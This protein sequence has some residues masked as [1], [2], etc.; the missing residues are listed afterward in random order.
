[1]QFMNCGN[2]IHYLFLKY[3]SYCIVLYVL[4]LLSEVYM[5]AQP[6]KHYANTCFYVPGLEDLVHCL[7][8]RYFY[9]L[10]LFHQV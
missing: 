6:T 3:G 1:M 4:K 5:Y 8:K 2:C 9:Q 10:Q 7:N